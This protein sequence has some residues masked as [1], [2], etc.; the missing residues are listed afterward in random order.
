MACMYYMQWRMELA[1]YGK[2]PQNYNVYWANT[3]GPVIL[4]QTSTPDVHAKL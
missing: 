1:S 2:W 4:L 3:Y